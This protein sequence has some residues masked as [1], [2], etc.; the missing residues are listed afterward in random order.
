MT[1]PTLAFQPEAERY[2]AEGYWR[3]GDLWSDFDARADEH[4]DR[5]ALVLDDRAVTYDELRRAAIGV[6]HRLADGGVA[7]RRRRDPARPP[8]DRGGG[9]DARLPAP[10][11]RARAAAAD[12]QRDPARRRCSSRRSATAIV[13]FGG[14]KE[15]AKCREVAGEV[16]AA[17][18]GRCRRTSTRSPAQRPAGRRAT[19]A[20]R[21]RPRAWSCTRRARRRRRRASRTRATRCATRPRASARAGG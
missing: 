15:I 2:Y 4:P 9:R 18:R 13:G 17:A 3:D 10:R 16:A 12:V 5:V 7:A 8:L 20:P 21:R 1:K 11:R 14:E 19:A 6:S